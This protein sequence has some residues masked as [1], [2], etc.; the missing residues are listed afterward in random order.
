MDRFTWYQAGEAG[1]EDIIIQA[2]S[3]GI[4]DGD[5]KATAFDQGTASLTLNRLIWADYGDP[6]CRLSLHHSLVKHIDRHNK[7]MFSRGGKIVIHLTPTPANFQG[8]GPVAASP[9]HSVRLNFRQG[10]DED[11]YKKFRDALERKTWL[12]TPSSSSSAGSRQSG[13]TQAAPRAVGISGIERRLAEQ[14]TRTQ[15]NISQAFEDLGKLMEMAKDMVSISKSISEKLRLKQGEITDDETVQFKS[16]LLSLGVSDP[17]T[18]SAFGSGAQYYEK[19]ANELATILEKPLKEC[20]GMMALPDV[21]CRVNRARGL[22][23]LSPEDLLNGCAMLVKLNLPITLHHFD[24]GVLVVQLKSMSVETTIEPTAK[25]V[26]DSDSAT[27]QELAQ[28]AGI[29]VV[30]AK[31]RLLATEEVGQI[32]RDDTIEGL[33]FYP[34]KFAE[35]QTAAS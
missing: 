30:L 11:F 14:N 5:Q 7:S 3:V 21:Y 10:G 17:V 12:R 16:Y 2:G 31:E 34:N 6:D 8:S 25:F 19:L 24:S 9:F 15:E 33:R 27:A 35:A 13:A 26:T 28:T 32:C 4:F 29:S 1:N 20:G 23:L 22:E 18:K